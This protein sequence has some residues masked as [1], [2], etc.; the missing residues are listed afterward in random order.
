MLTSFLFQ[1]NQ[2]HFSRLQ[3]SKCARDPS[4]PQSQAVFGGENNKNTKSQFIHLQ[5]SVL[6][7]NEP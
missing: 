6:P 4:L 1:N 2:L 3:I 5:K 7:K